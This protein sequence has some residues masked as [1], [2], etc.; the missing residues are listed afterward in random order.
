MRK[1]YRIFVL[2]IFVL[3]I[4]SGCAHKSACIDPSDLNDREKFELAFHFNWI[5]S[6]ILTEYIY[7][8]LATIKEKPDTVIF[9][10]LLIDQQGIIKSGELI[11]SSDSPA[12]DM[13][14]ESA[15]KN[16]IKNLESRKLTS[17]PTC[18]N[19]GLEVVLPVIFEP[20]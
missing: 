17:K 4:T 6:P 15:L 11:K 10:K 19:T 12:L 16:T 1:I 13:I 18:L 5:I 20:N 8:D 9:F 2:M 14:L 7:A 3:T